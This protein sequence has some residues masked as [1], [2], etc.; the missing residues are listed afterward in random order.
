MR[1][2]LESNWFTQLPDMQKPLLNHLVREGC[3]VEAGH[4]SDSRVRVR[5]ERSG[6]VLGESVAETLEL[7]FAGAYMLADRRLHF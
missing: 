4:D 6:R 7:A 5:V 2:P 3:H 1:E